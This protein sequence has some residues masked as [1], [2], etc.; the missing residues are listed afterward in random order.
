MPHVPASKADAASPKRR[1]VLV[2]GLLVG[3]TA[4]CASG[5]P[6]PLE[7]TPGADMPGW[8]VDGYEPRRP[9]AAE[10][11]DTDGDVAQTQP[12]PATARPQQSEERARPRVPARFT[13]V[14]Q[15]RHEDADMA[16]RTAEADATRALAHLLDVRIRRALLRH[17]DQLEGVESAPRD[18][19][20]GHVWHLEFTELIEALPIEVRETAV[21]EPPE[22]D[23]PSLTFAAALVPFDEVL[24][25]VHAL[26]EQELQDRAPSRDRLA[27][28]LSQR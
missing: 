9:L 14:G 17:V 21:D 13:A 20:R 11:Q 25:H 19:L 28:L 15:A 24:R 27:T 5:P 3:V 26:A 16:Q 8:V 1:R 6:E 4:A 7:R 22:V 23:G 12:T 18:A 10:P 2:F